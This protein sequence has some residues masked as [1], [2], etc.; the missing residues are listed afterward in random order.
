M[1]GLR[2]CSSCGAHKRAGACPHCGADGTGAVTRAMILGFVLAVGACDKQEDQA[3]YGIAFVDDDQ[4]GFS[5]EDD[6]ND[7][8]AAINPGA[9]ETP[10]DDVDSNCDGEDDT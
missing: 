1:Y 9:D 5:T 8:D 3:L 7:A 4:D 6:C 2:P 10:G